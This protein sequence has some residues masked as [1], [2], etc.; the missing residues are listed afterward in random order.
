MIFCYIITFFLKW[1]RW[2]KF[3]HRGRYFISNYVRTS[4]RYGIIPPTRHTVGSP[5]SNT[6]Q[7]IT[8][9]SL[10]HSQP[11]TMEDPDEE[12]HD[13]LV[14]RLS[15]GFGALLEQVQELALRNT[16]LEQR[17]ARVREEVIIRLSY[18]T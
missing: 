4:S 12:S 14:E 18:F 1:R 13:Q 5:T 11:I 2:Q 9:V 15:T 16:D 6:L 7:I 10:V 8:N 17:L 3:V